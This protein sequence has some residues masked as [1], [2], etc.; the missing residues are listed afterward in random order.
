MSESKD[1]NTPKNRKARCVDVLIREAMHIEAESAR[2]AGALG[3]MC[4]TLTLATMPH[5]KP[6][7]AVFKRSNGTFSMAMVAHPDIGLPYGAVP[8]LLIGWLT[9][10]ALR[11][12]S[13][14][15]EMG[16]TLTK[17]MQ[18]IGLVP[19]GGRWGSI[20]RLKEQTKRLFAC[21]ILSTYQGEAGNGNWVDT[22]FNFSIVDEYKLWWSP[23][24]PTQDSLWQSVVKLNANFYK[25][26]IDN[27]VPIDLRAIKAIKSSSMA[28]DIYCWL[29]YRN[30]YLRKPTEIPWPALQMQFGAGYPMTSKG[31]RN[32][33]AKFK[34]QLKRV[35]VVY[36]QAKVYEGEYGLVLKPSLTH[37]PTKAG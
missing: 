14:E 2:E 6:N 23:K 11:T 12:K 4:R 32:F 21:A 25:E 33:K 10:E 22:G 8:R 15:L 28:L 36:P 26:V 1:T 16:H 13:P 27:P 3:Y 37:I 19:T 20:T 29:T 31:T 35:L 24:S 30:S 17:F 34:Q 18:Q 9:T 5:S 7:E